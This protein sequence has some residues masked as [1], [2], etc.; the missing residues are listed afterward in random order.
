MAEARGA[1][2]AFASLASRLDPRVPV[3]VQTHDYPDIDAVSTA[4][5]LATLLQARGFA[6][7]VAHRGEP[8]SR[9]LARLVAELG[10]A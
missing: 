1:E 9:S 10:I 7:G 6:A 5:A 8:R 2:S 3:L 4:W